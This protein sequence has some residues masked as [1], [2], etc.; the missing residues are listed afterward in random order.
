MRTQQTPSD[1]DHS[2]GELEEIFII[3]IIN[4]VQVKTNIDNKVEQNIEEL[5]LNT[6]SKAEKL[7]KII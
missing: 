7:I 4:S 2:D 3:K 1:S 5:K 6:E